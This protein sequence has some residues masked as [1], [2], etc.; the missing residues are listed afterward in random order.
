MRDS[1]AVAKRVTRA[2]DSFFHVEATDTPDEYRVHSG[3]GNT[4][5]VN[6]SD[7]ACTCPDG[8]RSP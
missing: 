6:P 4:Y 5:T 8:Q 3:S 7:G 1:G 2:L